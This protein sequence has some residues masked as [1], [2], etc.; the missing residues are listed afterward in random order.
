MSFDGYGVLCICTVEEQSY[1]RTANLKASASLHTQAF[2]DM[3]S[4]QNVLTLLCFG[5][6]YVAST[7]THRNA[8]NTHTHTEAL[9]D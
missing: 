9:R 7:G 1:N 4:S 8:H 5:D 6:Q 3:R 2:E